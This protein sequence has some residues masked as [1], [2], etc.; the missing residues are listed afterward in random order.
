VLLHLLL[1]LL[2]RLVHV[3]RPHNAGCSRIVWIKRR[4]QHHEFLLRR[5]RCSDDASIFNHK[6]L[7]LVILCKLLLLLLLVLLLVLVVE[8]IQRVLLIGVILV[9]RL[10]LL[11]L[12]DLLSLN[13]IG[14]LIDSSVVHSGH[15]DRMLLRLLLLLLLLGLL[16]SLLHGSGGNDSLN[17]RNVH[18]SERGTITASRSLEDNAFHALAN[19]WESL[20]E[21]WMGADILLGS[22]RNTS[23]SP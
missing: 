7:L 14:D 11:L 3:I 16:V 13:V 9:M 4:R 19:R 6:L 22:F 15:S 21:Q 2:Q 10:D 8:V 20:E 5:H 18:S 17:T 1:L 23:E 12:E